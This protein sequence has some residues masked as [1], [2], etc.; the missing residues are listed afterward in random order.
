MSQRG[1]EDLMKILH[2][3]ETLDEPSKEILKNP[4]KENFAKNTRIAELE[5]E[6]AQMKIKVNQLEIYQSK[7]CLI[8][9][10]LPFSSNETY[11]SDLIDLIRSLLNVKTEP[12]DLKA[13]HLLGR[14]LPFNPP[15]AIA[16][17]VYFDKK[18]IIWTRKGLLR[19]E[20]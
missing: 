8:F 17:F 4:N 18:E 3:S 19:T 7:D 12:R 9:R 13:C 11:L 14:G 20:L 16:K 5:S 1:M 10:N 2:E 15:P 6:V